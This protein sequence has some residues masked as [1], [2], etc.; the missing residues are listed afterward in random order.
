MV[1]AEYS[2]DVAS[3]VALDVVAVDGSNSFL[4]INDDTT[5]S[6]ARKSRRGCKSSPAKE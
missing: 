3:S 5:T 2:N 6:T 1:V 4:V